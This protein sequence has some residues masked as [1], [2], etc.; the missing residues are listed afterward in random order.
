MVSSIF[1]MPLCQIMSSSVNKVRRQ[2]EDISC[3]MTFSR[4]FYEYQSH[5]DKIDFIWMD[6]DNK[7]KTF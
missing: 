3:G 6:E 5:S 7:S 1:I 4:F 2:T